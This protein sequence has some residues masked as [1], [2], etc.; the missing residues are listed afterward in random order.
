MTKKF[1][2]IAGADDFLVTRRGKE[3]FDRMAE[4]LA[5]EFAQEIIDGSA[6]NV[7]EVEAAV[8]Q[9]VQAVTTLPM[10]GGKKAVWLKD[11]TFL[12]DTKTGRAEGTLE[13]VERLRETLDEIDPNEV[14]V[15]FT[16]APVDRRRAFY[17]WCVKTAESE[18]LAAPGEKGAGIDLVA[19]ACEEAE[20]QG[21]RFTRAAAELLIG[22]VNG[23]TRL[24]VEETAKLA[25]Y[26]HPDGGKVEESLVREL[27]PN[28]GE[29]DFFETSDAFFALD[30]AWTLEAL[31]RHFFSGN[32]ARPLITTLQGR[33]RLLIQLRVLLDAGE[34]RLG[35]G[36]DK[37]SL[38]RA[39]AAYRKAFG[40]EPEKN[41]F[42][43]FTQHPFYLGRLAE[44]AKKLNLKRLIDFQQE[45][46]RAFEET[47]SRPDQEEE[48]LREMAIRCLS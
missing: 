29:G 12:A 44:S 11:V 39:A 43:V 5:D 38:E 32:S 14:D 42:N 31:R 41:S 4:G 40:E 45:F 48:V 10:F 26:L 36:V 24:I 30:L 16:A 46:L 6:N 21:L 35:R 9:F 23:N 22:K 3:I 20:R 27:V 19:M 18:W 37:T 17:K 47:I 25:A 15:L 2:F 34:I 8:G 28:F 13:Q 33:N 1:T 7:D